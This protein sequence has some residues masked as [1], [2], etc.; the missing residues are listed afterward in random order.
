MVSPGITVTDL[1]ADMPAR[2]KELEARRS[3]VRRL[4][5]TADTAAVVAFLASEAGGYLNGVNL[6]VTGGPV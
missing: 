2:L 5:T 1:T 4:A 3:P 6:P